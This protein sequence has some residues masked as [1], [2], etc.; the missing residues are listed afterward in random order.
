MDIT[1]IL[2]YGFQY[3]AWPIAILILGLYTVKT[4]PDLFGALSHK[5]FM[6]LLQFK[7]D[8]KWFSD[9]IK[10]NTEGD[11]INIEKAYKILIDNNKLY[12]LNILLKR[13]KSLYPKSQNVPTIT[14][15]N[16]KAKNLNDKRNALIEYA[17][18]FN[19]I[20]IYFLAQEALKDRDDLDYAAQVLQSALSQLTKKP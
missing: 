19:N 3:L 4:L 15:I 17:N 1:L 20:I 5:R 7:E 2:I 16:K 12:D 11:L 14:K 6:V 13:Y 18:N 10:D 9:L 8:A